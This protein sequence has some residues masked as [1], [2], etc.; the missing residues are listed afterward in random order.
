MITKVKQTS[1]ILKVQ[2]NRLRIRHDFYFFV[3]SKYI[4]VG[5]ESTITEE[6]GFSESHHV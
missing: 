5:F 1:C 2:V 4:V 6:D 3:N